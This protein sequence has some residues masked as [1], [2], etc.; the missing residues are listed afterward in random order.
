LEGF[1]FG[2]DF[3]PTIDRIRIVSNTAQNLVAHPDTGD[4][5]VASTTPVFYGVGDPNAGMTPNVVHHAY[6]NNFAGAATSQLRAIDVNLQILVTQANNAGTLGTIGSIGQLAGASGGFDVSAT[7]NAFASFQVVTEGNSSP[8]YSVNLQTGAMTPLGDIPGLV[9]G[10]TVV[11][12]PVSLIFMFGFL[13]G[14]LRS[15]K[16]S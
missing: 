13:V 12:E 10:L 3:N 8:L 16:T 6:D 11:P 15:R 7:G 9:S 5:N 14:L 1:S 4:A 2:F